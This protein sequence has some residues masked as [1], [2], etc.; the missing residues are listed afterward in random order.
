MRFLFPLTKIRR[1]VPY[2]LPVNC[3]HRHS[4]RA[5]GL[6]KSAVWAGQS[7][8]P[9]KISRNPDPF[10]VYLNKRANEDDA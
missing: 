2:Y 9:R 4:A 10:P 7:A 6:S 3:T 8:L 5:R 1:Y